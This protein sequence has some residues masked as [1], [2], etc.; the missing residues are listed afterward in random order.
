MTFVFG[1]LFICPALAHTELVATN[2]VANSTIKAPLE[3]ISLTFSE[4]PLLAGSEIDI[5]QPQ[6]TT[7][8]SVPP[9]LTNT[10]LSVPWPTNIKPGTVAVMWRAVS[11]DGHIATSGFRFNYIQAST[12]SPQP[13]QVT[14]ENRWRK[15]GA[16]GFL[17]LIVVGLACLAIANRKNRAGR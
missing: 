8:A 4:A 9:T 10:T 3:S 7:I 11:D 16:V 2:P 1:F 17:S 15:I 12:S 5:Q 13:A 6:G 14:H